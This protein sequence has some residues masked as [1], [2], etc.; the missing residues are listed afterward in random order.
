MN[1]DGTATD[2]EKDR[3]LHDMLVVAQPP[4]MSPAEHQAVFLNPEKAYGNFMGW[5][6]YRKYLET[7]FTAENIGNDPIYSFRN[8]DR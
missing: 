3:K 2:I 6:Q 4:H 7:N 1:H 5:K 8:E